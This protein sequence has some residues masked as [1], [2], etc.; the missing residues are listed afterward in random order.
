MKTTQAVQTTS[1]N[2]SAPQ[3]L[4][5][6]ESLLQEHYAL[7]KGNQDG[8]VANYIPELAKVE[9]DEFGMAVATQ[10]GEIVTAGDAKAPFTIQSISKAYTF[11]MLLDEAGREET[12][13]AVGV[14][15]SGDPFNAITLDARTNRPFNPMVNAGAIAVAGRLRQVLG[16][17]AFDRVLDLF[18][19]AA[20]RA[21][22]VDER[23]FESEK[24]T[25]HRNRAIGHLLRA[26]EVFDVPVDDVLDVY[27]RQCSIRV[28]A[29]D[30]AVMGATLANLGIN[31][32]TKQDVFGMDAVRYTLS[33]MFTCGMYD[34]AGD[35]ATRVGLPAKSGVGGGIIAV[36]NRQIGIGVFSPR[37]DEAGNSVRGKLCCIGLADGLGLHAFDATNPGSS[38]LRGMAKWD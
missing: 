16:A 8:A 22:D 11:A 10:A 3:S 20:G 23:V 25:G 19:R 21:L 9:P 29:T 6:I 38:F 18:S 15:P 24:E 26:A 13:A 36:V 37:L 28:T 12:Y 1:T 17:G 14:Q 35:W 7:Y 5:E 2:G 32:I 27:F 34:G 30:L 33:V 31:P 4:I